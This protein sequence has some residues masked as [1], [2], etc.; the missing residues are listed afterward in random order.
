MQKV[1]GVCAAQTFIWLARMNQCKPENRDTKEYGNMFKHILTL[2][3]LHHSAQ[4]AGPVVV[5]PSEGEVRET[6]DALRR[7]RAPLPRKR[8]GG[9]PEPEAQGAAV[10]GGCVAA[11]APL[12]VVPT[13][14]GEDSVDGSTV[15][16]LLAE[17]L[18]LTK[19]EEEEVE[20]GGEARDTYAGT[21]SP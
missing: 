4:P 15:S 9:P 13:L 1:F 3:A 11:G 2:T 21:G 14:H 7:L 5:G 19:K 20:G 16:F 6:Y 18:K 12:L 17:N 8:P 10:M